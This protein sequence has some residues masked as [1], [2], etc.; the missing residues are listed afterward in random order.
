MAD[1]KLRD[2]WTKSEK[3]LAKGNAKD[4]LKILRDIDPDGENATTLRIAGEA[5]WSLASAS[6]SKSE[7]R[8]AASLLR[9][10]VKKDPRDKKANNS[11]NSILNEMQDKRIKE[12][13]L[14]RL[15]NDG[16]PTFA[17]IIALFASIILVLLVVKAASTTTSDLATEATL[18]LSWTNADGTQSTGTVVVELYAED[19]PIH[20]EN[21]GI[22]AEDGNY[23]ETVFHR[24]ISNFMMQGGD[25]TRG[26]GSGGHAGKFFGY[27]NGQEADSAND[28]IMSSY[29]IPDE[30]DNGRTH[31]PYSLSMAKTSAA[32]TGGSQFFIVDPDA[33]G[34]DG[35]PGTPHLD[36]VHTVFGEVTSGFEHID[37]ITALCDVSQNCQNDKTPQDVVLESVTTNLEND[38]WWKFW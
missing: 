29:T 32:H 4:S 16:T 30:A 8:K 26:D 36:G 34:E 33:K 31:A 35:S 25:F 6:S 15:V 5:T 14:P 38:S 20:V 23:D 19:A 24:I 3:V 17:G 12:T 10:S 21:F 18:E 27:C 2:A 37:A 11:Y 13:T 1:E 28:C 7:Y 22:L 9:D